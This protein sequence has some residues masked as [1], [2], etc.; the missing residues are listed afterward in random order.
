[1]ILHVSSRMSLD[2][3]HYTLV[4]SSGKIQG[5]QYELKHFSSRPNILN[6]AFTF[7]LY[8]YSEGI[9][10]E[11]S[12]IRF[13]QWNKGAPLCL[14]S[15]EI[16]LW[17]SFSPPSKCLAFQEDSRNSLGSIKVFH[18]TFWTHDS[19][20]YMPTLHAVSCKSLLFP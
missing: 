16:F 14:V 5:L 8:F 2:L 18:S 17:V 15:Y 20:V 3:S 9:L 19:S 13:I 1:M 12:K 7:E 11:T 6:Y 4:F 10:G